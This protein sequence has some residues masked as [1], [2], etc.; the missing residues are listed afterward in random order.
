MMMWNNGWSVGGWVLMA[1]LMIVFW[2]LVIGGVIWLLRNSSRQQQ[3][4]ALG[5]PD[6]QQI[7]DE[8]FARGELTEVEYRQRRDLL[9]ADGRS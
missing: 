1:L 5:Q 9:H 2:S 6:A 8:R 4:P 7:L 3:A